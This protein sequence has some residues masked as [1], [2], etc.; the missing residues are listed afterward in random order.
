MGTLHGGVNI[1]DGHQNDSD[2][3]HQLYLYGFRTREI[4]SSLGFTTIFDVF[5]V[6]EGRQSLHRENARRMELF[7]ICDNGNG[8]RLT[9]VNGT[10]YTHMKNY[11]T[12]HYDTWEILCGIC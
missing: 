4:V 2:A 12:V 10:A 9:A 11:T 6:A 8:F 1:N 7:A 5:P 3:Q